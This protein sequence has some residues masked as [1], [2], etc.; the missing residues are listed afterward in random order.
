MSSDE[1]LQS[2]ADSVAGA[3]LEVIRTAT[4]YEQVPSL[5]KQQATA[6]A[7]DSTS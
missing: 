7:T 4:Q 5:T 2:A 6:R 3:I 1:N